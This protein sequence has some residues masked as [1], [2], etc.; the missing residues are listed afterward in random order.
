MIFVK[1]IERVVDDP[2]FWIR[3]EAAFAIGALAKGVS[4]E[5]ANASLV[6]RSTLRC[7]LLH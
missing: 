5:T 1:E 6:R 4:S 7:C 3:R 2:I